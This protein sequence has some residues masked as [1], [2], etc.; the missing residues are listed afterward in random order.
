MP[1]HSRSEKVTMCSSRYGE[2]V[3]KIPREPWIV[4]LVIAAGFSFL[5]GVLNGLIEL[6]GGARFG[7]WHVIGIIVLSMPLVLFLAV[8]LRGNRNLKLAETQADKQAK[9]FR[10]NSSRAS[11]YLFRDAFYGKFAGFDIEFD[12]RYL[13]QTR[14]KTFMRI[15]CAPGAHLLRSKSP[16]DDVQ[17]ELALNLAVGQLIF[18]VH[19]IGMTAKGMRH[20]LKI[21]EEHQAQ[22]RIKRCRLLKLE[23]ATAP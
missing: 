2:P 10:A 22:R 14:G 1:P 21:I 3:Q 20:A 12:G 17:A 6:H 7:A 5:L 18:V 9:Q 8:Q 16:V 15:D 19:E 23:D 11:V 13:G 4:M